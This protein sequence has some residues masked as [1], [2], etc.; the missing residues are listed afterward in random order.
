VELSNS[1]VPA[2]N[3]VLNAPQHIVSSR[4]TIDAHRLR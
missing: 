3:I 2:I 4:G 1:G